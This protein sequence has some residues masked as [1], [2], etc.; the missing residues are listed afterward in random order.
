MEN[1]VDPDQLASEASWS[2]FML[3]T[4]VYIYEFILFSK[5]FLYGLAHQVLSCVCS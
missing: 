1:S 5:E 2:G 4:I 3:F